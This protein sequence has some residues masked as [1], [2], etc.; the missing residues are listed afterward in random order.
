MPARGLPIAIPLTPML[1]VD[2]FSGG[3]VTEASSYAKN[4]VYGKY[5]GA[6]GEIFFATQR[7][8]INI[9]EDASD[10]VSD[11]RGRGVFYWDQAGKKY[12]V[13]DDTVYQES[14]GGTTMAI[15]SGTER[16]YMFDVGDYLVLLDPE[17]N[18]GWYIAVGAPTTIVQLTNATHG[19]P[20]AFVSGGAVLNGKL[21]VMDANADIW[22]C[23]IEDP[24]SW[25]AL[26]FR[27]AEV[28]PDPG[29]HLTK[30][31][32]QIVALGTRTC[33]FFYDAGNPTG[34]TLAARTDISYE[35]GAVSQHSVWSES[36]AL[37]FVGQTGSGSIGVYMLE[38]MQLQKISTEDMDTFL[39]TAV[40]VDSVMLT[41]SGF[42]SGGRL[43]YLL[44]LH[45]TPS[46]IA[47]EMTLC[48]Q[49][50]FGWLGPWDLM[51]A[52][53]DD[54]PVVAWTPSTTTRAGEGILSN[55]DLVT[56]VDDMHPQDTVEASTVF[57]PDVFVG[58]VFSQTA[59]DGTDIAVEIVAGQSDGG[60][61]RK[62]FMGELWL[63][64]NQTEN[65][66]VVTVSV[67]D[68]QNKSFVEIGTIDAAS[69]NNRINRCGS[70]RQRNHKVSFA[71]ADQLRIERLEG[72]ARLGT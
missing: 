17:N 2:A 12:L 67:A 42:Q 32:E 69:N 49:A 71:C 62:K 30:H 26:N 41:A 25:G 51:H 55:G 6:G 66:A 14:Y 40:V 68:E 33:E 36:G 20:S 28:E 65:A 8:G 29:V 54:F 60:S 34:S 13:N 3:V 1:K 64:A 50:G 21:F 10:T 18:E 37:I 23:D 24:L 45:Y 11:A 19:F 48:Y 7:P 16:V 31:N 59:A 5:K 38:G 43:F 52:G 22:E 53:I 39:T 61:R 56:V 72:Y 47:P 70:F 46:D 27:E 35:V 44:T 57:E 4:A 9:F 15:S 58:G 63:A